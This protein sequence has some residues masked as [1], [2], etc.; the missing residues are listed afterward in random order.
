MNSHK[1]SWKLREFTIMYTVI[2]FVKKITF[3]PKPD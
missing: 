3:T 2:G 1:C